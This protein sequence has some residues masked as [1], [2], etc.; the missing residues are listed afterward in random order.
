MYEI[1][2]ASFEK[3]GALKPTGSEAKKTEITHL[4]I[5]M[6]NAC[7]GHK[8]AK[9]VPKTASNEN[10]LEADENA[11]ALKPT[12]SIQKKTTESVAGN[13]PE[14]WNRFELKPT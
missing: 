12:G 3:A 8:R 10:I 1:L 4:N 9:P 13:K 2:V 6:G 5:G 11:G 14:Y 7:A